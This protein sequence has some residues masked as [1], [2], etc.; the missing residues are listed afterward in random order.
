MNARAVYL[1]IEF[2]ASVFSPL[3]FEVT[4]KTAHD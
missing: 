2:S 3:M 4:S 1:F